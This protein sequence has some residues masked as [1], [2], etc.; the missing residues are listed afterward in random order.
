MTALGSTAPRL[1]AW[2][3]LFQPDLAKLGA[4]VGLGVG[5]PWAPDF[6]IDALGAAQV[7]DALPLTVAL[8]VWGQRGLHIKA[9]QMPLAPGLPCYYPKGD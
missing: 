9:G 4:G 3:D 7:V 1:E 6:Y 8:E 5:A 2:I